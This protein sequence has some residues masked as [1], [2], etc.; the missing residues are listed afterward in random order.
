MFDLMLML[1][2]ARQGIAALQSAAAACFLFRIRSTA[3][4]ES[5][6][7]IAAALPGASMFP[8]LRYVRKISY[9]L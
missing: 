8:H 2:I 6:Y 1:T 4:V 3:A 7:L 5:F 9:S